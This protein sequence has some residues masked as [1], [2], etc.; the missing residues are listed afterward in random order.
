[1]ADAP[2]TVLRVEPFDGAL[3]EAARGLRFLYYVTTRPDGRPTVASG[4]LLL[5]AAVEDAPLPVVVWAHGTTGIAPGCAPSVLDDPFACVPAFPDLLSEGWAM[6][7]PD[8]AGLGT[9]GGHLYLVGEDAGRAVLDAVRAAR[10]LPDLPPL[11]PD[12]VVWGHSQG[13]HAALW[14]GQLAPTYA[15]DLVLRGV[16]AAASASDLSGLVAASAG[17]PF[18]K[19]VSVYL[20]DAYARA[21]PDVATGAWL[22]A[23]SARGWPRTCLRVISQ[24]P[25]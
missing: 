1:V 22:T 16:A 18:G 19:I 24:R 12:T 25:S 10:A 3:P 21:Y 8:Y 23:P 17:N 5:T 6:V 9:A 15:P 14:A 11:A 2:G 13:G 4:L 20:S 7:A